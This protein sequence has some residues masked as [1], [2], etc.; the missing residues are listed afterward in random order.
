MRFY[1]LFKVPAASLANH[2]SKNRDHRFGGE[3]EGER[4]INEESI[5]AV[6]WA[7]G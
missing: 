7:L 2:R 6:N 1:P 4:E 5:A 3:E